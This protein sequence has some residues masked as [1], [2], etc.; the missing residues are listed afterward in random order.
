MTPLPL[1][2][3]DADLIGFADGWATVMEAED[4]EAAFNYTEHLPAMH[5]TPSL[6]REVVKAYDEARE[7]QKVTLFGEPTDIKQRK[8]VER[9]EPNRHQFSGEIWYDLNIDHRVSDLTA[10]FHLKSTP[11]G[12]VVFLNDIHVM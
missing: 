4:Y 12:I 11:D 7:T 5:W 10:T 1:N 3:T 9:H 2:S 8:S 6:I